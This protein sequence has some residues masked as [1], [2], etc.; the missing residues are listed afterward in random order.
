MKPISKYTFKNEPVLRTPE[1]E[2]KPSPCTSRQM[3]PEEV[4][5]YK[6]IKPLEKHTQS[7]YMAHLK[8]QRKG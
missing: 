8:G 6:D 1:I 3:T 2:Q 7:D 5:R 4:E